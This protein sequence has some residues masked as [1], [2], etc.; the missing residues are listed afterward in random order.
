MQFTRT[1]GANARAKPT[2]ML[3]TPA[4]AAPY[5]IVFAPGL[6]DAVL[7]TKMIEPPSPAAMRV[8]T[9]AVSR[10]GPL[11]LTSSTLSYSAS[12]TS[13]TRS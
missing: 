3:F 7:E 8:P 13:L 2:V 1:F 9:S 10:N 11:R 5:G 12:V 4:F 6:C